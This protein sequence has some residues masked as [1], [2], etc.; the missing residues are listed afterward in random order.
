M[1]KKIGALFV[2]YNPSEEEILNIIRISSLYD[3]TYVYD[4]TEYKIDYID[5]MCIR[6]SSYSNHYIKSYT[7]DCRIAGKNQVRITCYI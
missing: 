2:L 6:D 3:I 7:I 4:N 5:K 1:S